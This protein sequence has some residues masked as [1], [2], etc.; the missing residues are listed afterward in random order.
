[1][2]KSLAVLMDLSLIFLFTLISSNYP[3]SLPHYNPNTF[4]FFTGGS[5]KWIRNNSQT[6]GSSGKYLNSNLINIDQI[7]SDKAADTLVSLT[8]SIPF[9]TPTHTSGEV[10]H[11]LG[12]PNT[13]LFSLAPIYLIITENVSN[14]LKE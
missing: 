8:P 11:T 3:Q 7:Y 14:Q 1:M 4:S 5:N 13:S 12:K 2:K 6:T 9:Y 10:E